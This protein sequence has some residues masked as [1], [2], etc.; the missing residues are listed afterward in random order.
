MNSREQQNGHNFLMNLTS[1]FWK[2]VCMKNMFQLIE[3]FFQYK[4]CSTREDS[5]SRCVTT[6]QV[7]L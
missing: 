3:M 2:I 4:C 7:K 1:K 5:R 6:N